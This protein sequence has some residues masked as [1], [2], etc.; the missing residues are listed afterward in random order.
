MPKIF[1][2]RSSGRFTVLIMLK[3]LLL[4][5]CG[6][7]RE[8]KLR[9]IVKLITYFLPVQERVSLNILSA[10]HSLNVMPFKQI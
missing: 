10:H 2:G 5:Y 6:A 3:C 9:E 1:E 7:T 4:A 8:I